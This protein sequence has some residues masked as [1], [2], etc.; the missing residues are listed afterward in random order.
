M[1]TH[2]RALQ[3]V[4]AGELVVIPNGQVVQVTN[5]SSEWARAV[6]DVPL[7]V[8]VDSEGLRSDLAQQLGA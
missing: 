4:L 1:Q 2:A 8:D 5:P 7:P 3:D 6:V